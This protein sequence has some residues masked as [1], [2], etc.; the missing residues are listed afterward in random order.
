MPVIVIASSKGGVGKSTTAIALSAELAI[1]CKDSGID[2]TLIDADQNQHSAGWALLAGRPSNLKLIQNSN[3]ES[4]LDDI[5]D[6][7]AVSGFVIVDLEGTANM[8]VASAISRATLVIIMCQGSIL[9]AKEA[10]K[11]V[12]MINRQ[13]RVLGR[14]IA[15]SVLFTRTSAAIRSRTYSNIVSELDNLGIDIF[16]STLIERDAY[17]AL[18]SFGGPINELDKSQ[19]PGVEKATKDIRD[20]TKELKFKLNVLLNGGNANGK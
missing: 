11:T 9:D 1:Q 16:K 7:D 18:P 2:V 12:K 8:S 13:E 6:A 20:L 10:V 14:S 3:E 17:K 15:Y 4:I 19:V 5:E